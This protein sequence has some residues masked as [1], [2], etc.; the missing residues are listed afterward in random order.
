MGNGITYNTFQGATI[1]FGIF[2]NIAEAKLCLQDAISLY[3]TPYHLCF[4]YAQLIV[5]IP[6]P[7]L[8]VW[9]KYRQEPSADHVQHFLDIKHAYLQSLRDIQQ[10]LTNRGTSLHNF[11]FPNLG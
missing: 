8:D 11:G 6:A 9:N 1:I 4:L 10:L 7:A 2:A 5:V 3:Y